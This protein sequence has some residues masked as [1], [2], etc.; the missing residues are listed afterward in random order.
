M[1][2]SPLKRSVKF[3]ASDQDGMPVK[4][5]QVQ[6]ACESCRKKKVSLYY[7]LVTPWIRNFPVELSLFSGGFVH[8]RV[9]GGVFRRHCAKA[10]RHGGRESRIKIIQG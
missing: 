6:H 10:R 8:K 4:R 3:V 5:R 2:E 7:D 1:A 9:G